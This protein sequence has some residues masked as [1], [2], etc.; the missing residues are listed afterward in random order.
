M[1]YQIVWNCD[2]RAFKLLWN[3]RW[4]FFV[5]LT[6]WYFPLEPQYSE[7]RASKTPQIEIS[8]SIEFQLRIPTPPSIHLRPKA[9]LKPQDPLTCLFVCPNSNE[10]EWKQ[11]ALIWPMRSIRSNWI[12][13]RPNKDKSIQ[14]NHLRGW[15]LIVQASRILLSLPTAQ[16][17]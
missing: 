8:L 2:S 12:F 4:T 10:K 6:D 5:L 14:L 17:I 11:H 9:T 16:N 13:Q 15:T 7:R 1:F 3:V